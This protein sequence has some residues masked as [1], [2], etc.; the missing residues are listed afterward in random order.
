[1]DI[2]KRVAR[3]VVAA[4]GVMGSEPAGQTRTVLTDEGSKPVSV[5]LR[6]RR[7]AGTGFVRLAVPVVD[8]RLQLD[9]APAEAREVAAALVAAA[10]EAAETARVVAAPPPEAS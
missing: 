5:E 3:G 8:G 7:A 10:E 9:L 6:R 4:R 2:L 1:M